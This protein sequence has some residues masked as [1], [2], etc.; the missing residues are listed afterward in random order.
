MISLKNKLIVPSKNFVKLIELKWDTWAH[1][2]SKGL[3]FSK[4]S[5]VTHIV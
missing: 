4:N 3:V 2:T 1:T 5:S